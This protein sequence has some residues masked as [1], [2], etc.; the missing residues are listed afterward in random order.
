MAEQDKYEDDK[1][2]GLNEIEH[3][4]LRSDMYTGP[5]EINPNNLYLINSVENPTCLKYE[6][7]YYSPAWYKIFDELIVNCLD[8]KIKFPKLV[9]K[10]NVSFNSI[11]NEISVLNNGPGITTD[12][13]ECRSVAGNEIM[14]TPQAVASRQRT[15][16][17]FTIEDKFRITGGVNGLGMTLTNYMSK[18]FKLETVDKKRTKLIKYS[19][20][21]RNNSNIT[22][23]PIIDDKYKGETYTEITYIADTNLMTIELEKNKELLNRLIYTRLLWASLYCEI[24]ITYTYISKSDS[25]KSIQQIEKVINVDLDKC[26]EYFINGNKEAITTKNIPKGKNKSAASSSSNS[27]D[28]P[29]TV[30]MLHNIFN[31]DIKGPKFENNQFYHW[32]IGIVV[33]EKPIGLQQN[34]TVNGIVVQNGHHFEHIK[35]IIVEYIKPKLQRMLTKNDKRII[36]KN[37]ILSHI[38]LVMKIKIPSPGWADGQSK[39]DLTIND[40]IVNLSEYKLPATLLKQIWDNMQNYILEAM[41]IKTKTSTRKVKYL[42]NNKLTDATEAGGPNSHLCSLLAA[43]GD[44]AKT[45][46]IRALAYIGFKYYGVFAMSGVPI[47]T[48]KKTKELVSGKQLRCKFLEDSKKMNSFM[49]VFGLDYNLTYENDAEYKTLRYGKLIVATDQDVDGVGNIFGLILSFIEQFWPALLKR[50]FVSRLVTPVVMITINNPKLI[51]DCLINLEE[52]KSIMFFMESDFDEWLD[53]RQQIC[54]NNNIPTLEALKGF[55]DATYFKG[56]GRLTEV[57]IEIIFTNINNFIVSIKYDPSERGVFEIYYGKDTDGRKIELANADLMRKGITQS[58]GSITCTEQLRTETKLYNLCKIRRNMIHA[59]DGLNYAR[60]KVLACSQKTEFPKPKKIFVF[61]G[62]IT[63]KM[64]YHHGDM[65]INQCISNC[66]QKFRGKSPIPILTGIGEFG[67]SAGEEAG[68][69]RYIEITDNKKVMNKIF[70]PFDNVFLKYTLIDGFKVEPDYFIPIIPFSLLQMYTSPGSGW[71]TEVFAREFTSIVDN[72]KEM[73][74]GNEPKY[75][76]VYDPWLNHQHMIKTITPKGKKLTDI[77][78]RTRVSVETDENGNEYSVGYYEVDEKKE[79]LTITALPLGVVATKVFEKYKKKNM[80]TRV[81]NQSTGEQTLITVYFQKGGCAY[82]DGLPSDNGYSSIENNFEIVKKLN[83]N[84]NFYYDRGVLC[85]KTYI[86]VLKYWFPIRM[87]VYKLRI[88]RLLI[89]NEIKI[90]LE[91]NI[92]R[93]IQNY[94]ELN[95]IE[96]EEEVANK[97]LEKNKYDKFNVQLLNNN[98]DIKNEEL[99]ITITTFEASYK[100]L[101]SLKD[102]QK[103]VKNIIARDAKIKQL[104]EENNQLRNP[105]KLKEIWLSELEEL[106]E[107]VQKGIERNW[108]KVV[109]KQTR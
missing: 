67:T 51:P 29:N 2:T 84:I 6:T 12:N 99:M 76:P 35:N 54:L 7:V 69:A 16:G 91:K 62:R 5:K 19:Q 97:I 26:L 31:C 36:T 56:L 42:D 100:Y 85:F 38:H 72:V 66:G 74:E 20:V 14:P 55:N 101:S 89:L 15:G 65:S 28:I 81:E 53:E 32:N 109:K 34:S 59:I 43:E 25:N 75:M 90:N 41:S 60:R 63:E 70:P 107:T 46:L 45:P 58:S 33:W 77:Y 98:S 21:F 47:N 18:Y 106:K 73:L 9:T 3:T 92:V 23:S 83:S 10:I 96:I 93:Y 105:N 57:E 87:N 49:Q 94:K 50:G 86:D 88:E 79:T 71:K 11:T 17:T 8:H 1:I 4:I 13:M 95:L 82:Y 102:N 78:S 108:E 80:V 48:R 104:I 40:K 44:S 22:E 61:G 68:S 52:R 64:F 27:E 30:N 39:N 103:Y 24:P 37:N